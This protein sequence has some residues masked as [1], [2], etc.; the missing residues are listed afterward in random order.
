MKILKNNVDSNFKR[1]NHKEFDQVTFDQCTFVDCDFSNGEFCSC[2]FID[3]TFKNCNL[4]MASVH[5]SKFNAVTFEGCKLMGINWSMAHWPSIQLGTELVFEACN[6]SH[7]S[8]MALFL[9]DLVI[10][11]SKV[12]N[13]D[14]RECDLK[15]AFLRNNDFFSSQF[16]RTNLEGVR[17]EESINFNI[18]PLEN[19]PRNSTIT[20]S[21][22]LSLLGQFNINW[23]E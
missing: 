8:F 18:N 17:L 4:N 16:N 13:A 7:C 21:E 5:K 10:D 3:S 9:Q 19:N 6:L 14:F 2:S 12:H 20:K 1:I 11:N 23:V 15:N 22:A